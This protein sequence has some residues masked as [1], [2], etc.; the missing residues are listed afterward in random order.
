MLN[1]T[2]HVV[3]MRVPSRPKSTPPFEFLQLLLIAAY[4]FKK[5][6]TRALGLSRSNSEHSTK[7]DRMPSGPSEDWSACWRGSVTCSTLSVLLSCVD[8]SITFLSTTI[9]IYFARV[10]QRCLRPLSLFGEAVFL[11]GD[12]FSKF[13]RC[14]FLGKLYLATCVLRLQENASG[15]DP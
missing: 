2:A 3:S 12:A 15:H 8:P 10:S 4:S 11:E 5:K 13:P 6:E 14:V 1:R 9:L 7:S